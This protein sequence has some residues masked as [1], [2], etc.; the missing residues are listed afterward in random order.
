MLTVCD[1]EVY[2]ARPPHGRTQGTGQR[3][4]LHASHSQHLLH[5]T[6]TG[7]YPRAPWG[8]ARYAI[9]QPH[10]ERFKHGP[11]HTKKVTSQ[12]P[13]RCEQSSTTAQTKSTRAHRTPLEIRPEAQALANNGTHHQPNQL[14]R[15]EAGAIALEG[16]STISCMRFVLYGSSPC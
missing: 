4:G 7:K 6:S 2:G 15:T 12:A 13:R 11:E 3:G 5:R 16:S 14:C 9:Q 8:L 1:G 10:F